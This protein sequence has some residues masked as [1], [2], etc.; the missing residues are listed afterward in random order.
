MLAAAVIP[1][2]DRAFFPLKTA[3][4]MVLRRM[5]VE[6]LEQRL[7]LINLHA[8]NTLSVSNVYEERFP[9]RFRVS[10]DDGM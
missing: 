4:K 10:A 3:G 1:K 9:A 2:G 5:L 6:H 8:L 7:A